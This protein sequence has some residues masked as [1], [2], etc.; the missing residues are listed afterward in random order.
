VS[1]CPNSAKLRYY[2]GCALLNPC[3]GNSSPG[4]RDKILQAQEQMKKSVE[5]NPKFHHAWYNLGLSSSE[6]GQA[7]SALVYCKRVLALQPNH[8]LTQ[9]LIG[10]VYGR[11]L[12]QYDLAIGHLQKAIQYNPKNGSAYEDLGI[13]HAMKGDVDA[14]IANFEKALLL[15]SNKKQLYTNLAVAWT[16]KG[17]LVKAKQYND[18]AAQ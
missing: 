1:A 8:I 7:D 14:A 3:I 13:C 5:I 17:D 2:Y 12:K 10:K 6:L 4:C 16:Q 15:S 9:Q 18:L 11:Y